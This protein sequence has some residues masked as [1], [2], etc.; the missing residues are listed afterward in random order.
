MFRKRVLRVFRKRVLRVF[1]KRVLRVFRKRVLRVFRK[2]MLR[3]LRRRVLRVFGKRVLR[4]FRKRVLA[5]KTRLHDKAE[6]LN[7]HDLLIL[8]KVFG[9]ITACDWTWTYYGLSSWARF[10]SIRPCTVKLF[11]VIAKLI[12]RNSSPETCTGNMP[13]RDYFSLQCTFQY[14]WRSSK[15][16]L[17][18]DHNMFRFRPKTLQ[19]YT[20]PWLID[21]LIRVFSIDWLIDWCIFDWLIDWCIFDW[22]IDWFT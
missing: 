15:L 13:R 9:R 3:V 12:F 8:T 2:R 6:S 14:I 10:R 5:E 7:I 20:C 16:N 1:R 11:A 19:N 17:I 4:V 18:P 21:W 22:L